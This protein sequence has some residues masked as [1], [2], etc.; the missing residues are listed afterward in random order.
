M[1]TR[2][3]SLF[4]AA[5]LVSAAAWGSGPS[6]SPFPTPLTPINPRGSL[7]YGNNTSGSIG[8]A[9][10]EHAYTLSVDPGQTI[11][12][13]V[14]PTA[15]PGFQPHVDVKNPS[16]FL[17]GSAT[18]AMPGKPVLLQ[19]VPASTTGTYTIIVSGASGTTGNYVITVFLN[20]A[21]EAEDVAG[22]PTDDSIGT[23]QNID[24]S[25]FSL[26][27]AAS[28][29]AVVGT[30]AGGDVDYYSFALNAGAS[31]TI[32]L[33]QVSGCVE[34]CATPSGGGGA[35]LLLQDSSA[36]T[37]AT[38][39]SGPT[40]VDLAI[41]NFTA[42]STGNYYVRVAGTGSSSYSLVVIRNGDFDF[43]GNGTLAHA[44]DLQD[45]FVLGD[46]GNG[47]SPDAD[48]Y[49]FGVNAGDNLVISTATPADGSGQFVNTLN[50]HIQLYD[51]DGNLVAS[52][53]V[54]A[55]GR[56]EQINYTALSTG[57]YRV[58]INGETGTTG[59]YVLE[60][61]GNTGAPPSAFTPDTSPCTAITAASPAHLWIGLRNSDDQ[62]TNFDLKVE[63][64]KNGNVV[65]SGLKRCVTGVTRNPSL[66]K[67]GIVD[68]EAFSAKPVAS[69]DVI[70]LRVS[71]RIGTNP[72]DTKC[73][74]HTSATALRLYYDSANRPSR[75]DATI[76]PDSS[77]DF[78]LHSDGT[79]CGSAQ[80][81][82]STF[83]LDNTA[84]V[85][86]NPRCRDSAPVSFSG[87]NPFSVIGTWSLA[88]LP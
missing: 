7:M 17:I 88:P 72:D 49:A 27:G 78:Y 31:V 52:G 36:N 74:G 63:L 80:S 54:M 12:V 43:E 26:G 14:I 84:P 32:A 1:S 9:G 87:G 53:T 34:G 60:F 23:A 44:E 30:A 37:L 24:A 48:Y 38:G 56:N 69:N 22:N 11:T 82:A 5:L 67:E 21:I 2:T 70:A 50:P 13:L 46:V 71:T 47:C 64:L 65:T 19:T 39:A 81:A 3:I 62:G 33:T 73:A 76:T 41:R 18:A 85:A 79:V 25:S 68:F 86:A 51:K 61:Q 58:E 8:F 57:A 55:D 40:N 20:L 6:T 28:R 16:N 10:E 45:E 59:E 42:P 83:T 4:V 75:L 29:L 15:S 35:T 66:A 77:K